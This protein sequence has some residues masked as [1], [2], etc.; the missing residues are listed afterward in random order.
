MSL[1]DFTEKICTKETV[2]NGKDPHVQVHGMLS[3]FQRGPTNILALWRLYLDILPWVFLKNPNGSF[4]I[5]CV[6]CMRTD[7]LILQPEFNSADR[8]LLFCQSQYWI[9]QKLPIIWVFRYVNPSY[10]Q[11]RKKLYML[12][13]DEYLEFRG[14]RTQIGLRW[15]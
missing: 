5:V 1:R 10:T 13:S 11:L 6:H 7:S 15:S 2:R 14:A 8:D 3:L 9:F 12:F 4:L